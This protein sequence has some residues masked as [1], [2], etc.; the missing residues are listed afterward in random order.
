MKSS[1]NKHHCFHS[2]PRLS[3]RHNKHRLTA[4]CFLFV[5]LFFIF[6]AKE[7]LQTA[8]CIRNMV[9]IKFFNEQ[10]KA[11]FSMSSGNVTIFGKCVFVP[12]IT[13]DLMIRSS[14]ET[15]WLATLGIGW[16]NLKNGYLRQRALLL[17]LLVILWCFC[18]KHNFLRLFVEVS[19]DWFIFM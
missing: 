16:E 9:Q 6:G 11:F 15:M 17:L 10:N 4:E 3:L 13:K 7:Y 14:N 2:L 18:H 12:V 8:A 5:C 1:I 19:L